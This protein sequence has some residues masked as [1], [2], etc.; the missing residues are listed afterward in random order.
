MMFDQMQ[1]EMVKQGRR[2]LE[3]N[4]KMMSW[5]LEQAE[6]AVSQ[7]RS[8]EQSATKL[9]LDSARIGMD[10]LLAAQRA[11]LDAMVPALSEKSAT[12]GQ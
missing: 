8:Q 9:M 12:N 11:T 4:Q 6:K 3:M 5:Q 7:W 10:S 2:A 1:Q